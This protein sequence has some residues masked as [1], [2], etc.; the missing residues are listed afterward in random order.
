MAGIEYTALVDEATA[1]IAV[2]T[3]NIGYRLYVSPESPWTVLTPRKILLGHTTLAET[4]RTFASADV[5]GEVREGQEEVVSW[6]EGAF[7][8]GDEDPTAIYKTELASRF[9]SLAEGCG[10]PVRGY[11]VHIH[12]AG[13]MPDP[14]DG[15]CT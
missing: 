3:S 5:P 11:E 1:A 2:D 14:G 4:Q 15:G 9:V 12:Q 8:M 6:V 13:W 7:Q 10:Q